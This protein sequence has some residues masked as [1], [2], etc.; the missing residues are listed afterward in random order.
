LSFQQHSTT[1]RRGENQ[2]R[3]GNQKQQQKKK[4][5]K[6]DGFGYLLNF[7]LNELFEKKKLDITLALLALIHEMV[8]CASRSTKYWSINLVILSHDTEWIS[9]TIKE[10]LICFE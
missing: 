3:I 10:R 1:I 6:I 2:R 9:K 5:S 4:R 8:K 7:D